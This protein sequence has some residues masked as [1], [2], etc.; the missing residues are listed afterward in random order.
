MSTSIPLATRPDI[1][2]RIL[3]GNP[4]DPVWTRPALLLL[5]AGTAVL[6]LVDLG[7]S[8]YGND[9]YAAAVQAGTKSW[10]AFLFGSFDSS[11]FIT[12]DKPPASLWVMAL[13]GRIFGFSGWSMLV[14]QALEGVAAVGLLYATVRRWF[15]AEAGLIAGFATALTPVAALMFRFNNPDA[16][17]VLLLVAGAYCVVRALENAGTWWLVLA[18]S[19]VGFAFLT[20]MLQ[21]FLVLPAFALVYLI[22][23]PTGL[24]RR[25]LQLLA[26]GLAIVVSAGW[27]VALVEFLP[28]R[29]RPYVGGSTNNSL[30]DLVWGYNGLGRITGNERGGGGG[31]TGGNRSLSEFAR[32]F[33]GGNGTPP[34][35]GGGPGGGAGGGFG[36][37]TGI[38]RMFGSTFGGE[39][40]WLLPAALL[41]LVTILV[42]TWRTPRTSRTRA[43]MILWGGWLLVTALV[44]SFMN[45]IIHEYYTVALAPAAAALIGITATLLWRHRSRFIARFVL[46]AMIVGSAIWGYVLLDRDSGWH[47][48]IRIVVLVVGIVAAIALLMPNVRQLGVVVAVLA[49]IGGLGSSTAYAVATAATPHTGSTPTSGPSGAG[50]G[51]V[52]MPGGGQSRRQSGLPGDAQSR[53]GGQFPGRGQLGNQQPGRSGAR[54]P[55]GGGQTANSAL[56]ALLK[57]TDSKWAAATVGSQS[58]A[59]LELSSGKAIMAIGGFSGTDPAPTLAQFKAYV[60]AGK[61]RYFIAGGG[62]GGGG[63]GGGGNSD[64]TSWV[65]SHF[66]SKAVGGE[67]VYDLSSPK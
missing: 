43:A 33:A 57:A 44:F 65:E 64:I 53:G 24:R 25:L 40:A 35:G 36:G 26:G 41:G 51:G 15:G 6:Y 37:P 30:L 5:L 4:Q 17:L 55:G 21:A 2:P 1:A 62:F 34:G 18:G 13:S 7:R 32:E 61:V 11:N 14:P 12:V 42:L 54:S 3:R 47:P 31:F 10:K 29:D 39:I 19:A 56:V 58:A 28:G 49:L 20:K 67:T 23:A 22:A 50:G 27:W 52:G 46:A 9:F 60:S 66:T 48:A 45:G 63:G 16:F 38:F 8:G 59:P